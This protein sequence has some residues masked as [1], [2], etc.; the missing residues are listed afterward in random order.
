MGLCTS[1]V[2][3]S[4]GTWQ[5]D[6]SFISHNRALAVKEFLTFVRYQRL[7]WNSQPTQGPLRLL[8]KIHEQ[9]PGNQMSYMHILTGGFMRV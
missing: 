4:L 6:G 9:L 2:F 3:F 8:V 7:L 1:G 5:T